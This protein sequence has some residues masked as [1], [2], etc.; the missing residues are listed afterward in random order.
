MKKKKK[1]PLLF[2]AMIAGNGL[3]EGMDGV[4]ENADSQN[5]VDAVPIENF[6]IDENTRSEIRS[7][8]IAGYALVID[9]INRSK[10]GSKDK[11]LEKLEEDD[12]RRILF[13]VWSRRGPSAPESIYGYLERPDSSHIVMELMVFINNSGILMNTTMKKRVRK[14]L[15]QWCQIW[16]DIVA[17][18][19]PV[20]KAFQNHGSR[21]SEPL[22]D[23]WRNELDP[24]AVQISIYD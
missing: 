22:K 8:A 13:E 4:P 10:R 16:K 9:V 15:K 6:V 11:L 2:A 14:S 24:D 12:P 23:F 19:E 7:A 18:N 1:L 5:A 17:K 21:F 20:E 3:V